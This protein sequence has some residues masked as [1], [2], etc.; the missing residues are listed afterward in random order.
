MRDGKIISTT[1]PTRVLMAVPQYPY[2]VVGGL[3]RQAHRLGQALIKLGVEVTVLSGKIHSCQPASE[4]V[5]G[6]QVVRILWPR[7]KSLRFVLLPIL[8]AIRMFR[9]HKRYDV[10]HIHNISWFG[11]FVIIIAKGMGKPV[12]AKLPNVGRFGLPGMRKG[13]LGSYKQKLLLSV[14]SVIAMCEES[15]QELLAAGYPKEQI[16][17]VTNGIVTR[18]RTNDDLKQFSHKDDLLIAFV[19]RLSPEKGILDLLSVWP[20]VVASTLR[21]AN[22]ELW[23]QGPQEEEIRRFIQEMDVGDSVKLLGHVSEVLNQLA[24]VDILVLPSYEE[25][26]SNVILE[27]METATPVIS[28][29]AGGTSLLVGELGRLWLYPPGDR[30]ALEGLLLSLIADDEAR[31]KLGVSLRERAQE[32]LSM[33]KVARRYRSAYICL[34]E[35]RPSEIQYLASPV[36]SEVS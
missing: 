23:G 28:T 24:R 11:V 14:E 2:P 10:V 25:G 9:L 7:W 13:F 12:L 30:K 33:E 3:E 26:N 34:A 36:F 17:K 1:T 18:P 27:A 19:G 16:F 29:F 20:R 21:R 5:E 8:I 32:F 35:G 15:I 6:V 31:R 22:L 4:T